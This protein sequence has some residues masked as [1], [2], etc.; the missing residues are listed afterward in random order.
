MATHAPI[1]HGTGM[2]SPPWKV[3]ALARRTGLTVRTLH[4]YD[5]IGL[6]A[7]SL[8]TPSGHRLY[9]GADVERLQQI[10]SLRVMGFSL[11]EVRRVLDPTGSRPALA[12]RE[13]I[14]L[15]LARVQEQIAR[16]TRLAERLTMLA[17]HLDTAEPV[18]A[19]DLCRL[20]EAMTTMDQY[21]TPEQ[22]DVLTE[23]RTR[24]G[25]ARA[26]E[27][28]DA[29]NAIIP[30][31]R[32]AMQQNV[33]PASP[34]VLALARRWKALVEEFTGGD[35]A[36]AGAV[37]TMYEHEGPTLQRELGEVPT[38]EMRAATRSA[39]RTPGTARRAWRR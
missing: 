38:P 21:F 30:A 23:R 19:D 12:P 8:R 25:D 3:G 35:P 17:N 22:L 20:I 31:V 11:D 14:A 2:S 9:T 1:T 5:A 7:P 24:I 37:R 18:T 13:I 36:I 15:H 6:L 33:D 10:Q 29:W 4:H 16:H 27:V 28:R 26:R 34:E 32:T 39:R